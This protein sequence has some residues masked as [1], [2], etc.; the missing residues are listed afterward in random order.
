MKNQMAKMCVFIL[1]LLSV[2]IVTG[3]GEVFQIGGNQSPDDDISKAIYNAVGRGKVRYHG[4][5]YSNSGEIAWYE[6]TVHD[7]EDENVLTNMVEAANA[8]MK[9][10]EMTEKKDLDLWEEIPGGDLVG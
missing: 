5:Q 2:M 8:V 7:Y 1:I 6:Y 3:C 4:K 9:E 10:K